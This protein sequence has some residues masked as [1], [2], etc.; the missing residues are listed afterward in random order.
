[1]HRKF[2]V[3]MIGFVVVVIGI[4]TAQADQPELSRFIEKHC[5]HCHGGKQPEAAFN[6]QQTEF[7]LDDS[8][9]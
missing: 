5:S 1:M 6:L 3:G 2:W 7:S 8:A 4:A 9:Q